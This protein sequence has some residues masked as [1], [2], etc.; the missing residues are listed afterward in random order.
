[1]CNLCETKLNYLF[2]DMI[3]AKLKLKNHEAHEG[4][5]NENNESLEK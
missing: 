3:C 1:M 5:N 4:Y 2:I